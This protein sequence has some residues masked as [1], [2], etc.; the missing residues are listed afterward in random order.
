M[1]PQLNSQ[2]VLKFGEREKMPQLECVLVSLDFPC[3]LSSLS[4]WVFHGSSLSQ[5]LPTPKVSLTSLPPSG[6]LGTWVMEVVPCIVSRNKLFSCG[7]HVFIITCLEYVSQYHLGLLE[8]CLGAQDNLIWDQRRMGW[9]IGQLQ[10]P[11]R[12]GDS[13]AWGCLHLLNSLQSLLLKCI[14]TRIA[15]NL[16]TLSPLSDHYSLVRSRLCP[17]HTKKMCQS[18]GGA[19]W[20]T[21]YLLMLEKSNQTT[22]YWY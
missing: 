12:Q 16:A 20:S 4:L 1:L 17:T 6:E 18:L 19:S 10:F 5:D 9:Y 21:F 22:W 13:L 8:E 14:T 3:L 15:I 2:T 11:F 7:L